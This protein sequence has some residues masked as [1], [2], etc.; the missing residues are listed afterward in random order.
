MK[1]K[2]ILAC[3]I[4]ILFLVI[5]A[6]VI[7]RS[8]YRKAHTFTLSGAETLKSEEIQPVSGVVRVTTTADTS[9]VFTD[10]QS[11][12]IFVLGYV[13]PGMGGSIKLKRGKWYRVE[14]SGQLTVSPVNVRIE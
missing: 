11:G 6:I 4:I 7:G 13:T 9:V 14:G 8:Q 3:V 12:E 5:C 10:A 2:K 1:N